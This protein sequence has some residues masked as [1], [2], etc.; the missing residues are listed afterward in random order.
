[1]T[2]KQQAD[3]EPFNLPTNYRSTPEL[4]AALNQLFDHPQPFAQP[5]LRYPPVGAADKPRASLRLAE[6]GEAAPLSL[7]WLGDDPLGKGDAAQLAAS[8][9]ARRIAVQLAAAAEDAQVSTRMAVSPCKGGDIAVLVAN[10]RQAGMIADEL[11]ARGVPS[12]RRGRDSVWR[13]E[14]AAELAAVL[15]AYAEPGREGLLRHALATR[16]LGRSAADLA[17]CQDDQ[18][19]W[20]AEREAAERYHQLWQQQGFMRVFRAWLDEQAVAERLLTRVD[21]ERRLT[22][23]LHLVSCCRPR[24]CCGPS[25]SRCSPGS[26]PSAAAKAPVKK[27]CCA[28]KAMPN[29]CRSSPST[30]AR[31][32]NTPWCSARFS[33]TASCSA[34]TRTVPVVTM[35]MASRC[36]TW[37]AAN[38]RTTSNAPAR[39]CSPNSCGWP[40]SP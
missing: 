38:W 29:G 12:V 39:R 9:T 31:G 28:W 34:R 15:A 6:E 17:R 19:E 26:T 16:L 20:D 32:W 14:E 37:A 5:D 33:G 36:W 3:R 22:N 25:S 23:L 21:G 30:P 8:D 11:A 18:H 35:P 13:S 27:R 10:H 1:M 24:A 7:V 40:T 4:I 2:A